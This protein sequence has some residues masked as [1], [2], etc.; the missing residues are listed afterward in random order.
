MRIDYGRG[1]KEVLF[2]LY[3]LM[4]YEQEFHSDPIHDLYRGEYEDVFFPSVPKVLWAGL[5]A[6]DDSIPGYER[7][8]R[9]I[10]GVNLRDLSNEMIPE[11]NEAFFRNGASDSE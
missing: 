11:I 10:R 6:A 1:E 8:S 2:S 4:I 5:K 9:D 7:W 3:S